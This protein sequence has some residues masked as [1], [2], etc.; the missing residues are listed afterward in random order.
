M[1]F[2]GTLLALVVVLG[3]GALVYFSGQRDR[4][5]AA[6]RAALAKLLPVQAADVVRLGFVHGDTR[7]EMEKRSA[8]W[9]L[10]QPVSANCD[11]EVVTGFLDTLA[12]ARI[13]QDLGSGDR[14]R[15]G[16]DHPA[17]TVRLETQSG[18]THE[19]RFGRINPLQTLVYV[20]VDDDDGVRLT[21]SALLSGALTSTFGWRDKRMIDVAI[22][23]VACLRFNTI[24]DGSLVVRRDATAGWV[25]DGPVAWR[26]DP[27][28]LQGLLL[29]LTA[30]RAIG[31]A[32]ENKQDLQ[33]FGLGNRKLSTILEDSTG[34]QVGDLVFGFALGEGAYYAIVP[35]KPEV[36]HVEGQIVETMQSLV[37]QPRDRR[38][39]PPFDPA[40]V[41]RLD[42]V[43]PEDRFVLERQGYTQ[44]RVRES[45][46][47][48]STFAID[49]GRVQ[50]LLEQMAALEVTDY[51]A[52]Q[53]GPN[54]VSPPAWNIDV[55]DANGLR[56]GLR[57]GRR[58]P[59]GGLHVFAQGLRDRA[60]FLLS[61]A[62]LLN[63]PFDIQRLGTGETE[64]PVDAERG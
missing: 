8:G 23:R 50:A 42:V 38:V 9:V 54:A 2:R 18:A 11:A 25:T 61:P 52:Q 27:V 1:K 45:D 35:D 60:V 32:A 24:R 30:L 17:A 40:A 64:V 58:D 56:S 34:A 5:V 37:Q 10:V 51:P 59:K 13:E 4:R 3:L 15:Y 41:T 36:F 14:V 7:I 22:E 31:V 62:V 48:D 21:T 57:I 53:P 63:L 33:P 28:R 43:A 26:V 20:L 29:Q 49:A 6:E 39:F 55:Y 44:W 16:L 12:A 46:K 19:L 47:V